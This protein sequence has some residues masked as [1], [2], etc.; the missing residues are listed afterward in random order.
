MN[1]LYYYFNMEYGKDKLLDKDTIENGTTPLISSKGTNNGILGYVNKKPSYKN[2]ISVPRTGTICYAYYQEIPCCINSD[3]IVLIPKK[4]LSPN[5]MIFISLL[6]RKQAFKYSYG[7]KVTPRRLGNT[8]IPEEFPKWVYKNRKFD[9]SKVSDSINKKKL[10]IYN[11]KWSYFKY[12]KVFV[13][14]RG[15]YNK[16]PET[17][18]NIN[19]ISASMHNN[20]VTDKVS[21]IGLEKKYNGNCITVVN[22][23]HAGEAFYQ[24]MDFTCSHDVNI[25][26]L[27]DE[28]MNIY[29]AMFLIPLFRKEKYRF[30]YGRKW[31][32]ERMMKSKI[33]LPI[34]NIYEP[35]WDFM[36]DYIKSIPYSKG[37]VEA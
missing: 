25:V 31:R 27:K 3:C 5:E 16:R 32:F 26:R 30:N 35:D 36:E 8:K 2:V 1:T 33:K 23:G 14:E 37:L 13:I 6:I 20:G 34:N 18:G 15:H 12:S 22:N 4:K 19:F 17:L 21:S 24:K 29:I 11:K 10:N 28:E 9:Y 7:R